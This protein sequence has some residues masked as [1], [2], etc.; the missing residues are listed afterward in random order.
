M[1]KLLAVLFVTVACATTHP[2]VVRDFAEYNRLVAVD[3]DKRLVEIT[4]IRRDVRYATTNNFMHAQ[5]YPVSKVFLRR[6]AA[7]ALHEIERELAR[8]GLG[9][10]LFDGYRPYRV[11]VRMWKPIRN[12]DFV[13]DPAKGSRHN[14]GAAVD[15]TLIDLRTGNELPMPT[16]YDDFTPRA[17]QDFNDLSPE[18]IANRAKLRDVMTRHGF[19]PLPSEWWHFDFRGWERFEL[20]DLALDQL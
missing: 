18:V 16:P 19:D 11:T 8:E 14:R 9:L 12:P 15:L 20:L 17:R 1:K 6:P 7:I 13:A 10:K 3:S 2:P 5:L 4:D